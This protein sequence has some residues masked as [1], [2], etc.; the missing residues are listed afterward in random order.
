MKVLYAF[1]KRFSSLRQWRPLFELI[2]LSRSRSSGKLIVKFLIGSYNWLYQHKETYFGACVKYFNTAGP[3]NPKDHYFLRHRL[4]WEQLNGFLEKKYY[5]LLHAPRQSGKT[6]AILEYVRYLNDGDTYTALYL[7]TE[8]AHTAGNDVER[9]FYWL[10]SQFQTEISDQLRNQ[11]EAL[12]FIEEEIKC[13]PVDEN[14]LYRFLHFWAKTNSKPLIIF[15]DEI[16]G[17]VE[18]SLVSLLKQFRTG[19]TKRPDLFPQS[20]CLIGVRNLQDYKLQSIE[21]VQKSILL[22]PFNIIAD[23][24]LLRNFTEDQVREL[25]NQHTQETGQVF[26]DEAISYAFYVTQG[27]PWLVN[28]LAYQAC[29]RDVIDRS[30]PITKEVMEGAKEQLILRKD[31][32][33][34]SLLERLHEK[35]V[36]VII[37][38]IISGTDPL[39]LNSDDLAYVR[40]LGLI[41]K[42]SWEIANPLYQQVIP[43]T[44]T[45]MLQDLIPEQTAWYVD[46]A[47]KLDMKKLIAAF[48]RF[49]RENADAYS[50]KIDYKESFPHLL[51]MAFLQR[52]VNGGGRICREYALGSKRVDIYVEWQKQCFILELK[53]KRGEDTER[54]G[55]EQISGYVDLAKPYEAHLLIFNRDPDVPWEQKISDEV[56]TFNSMQIHI[57]KM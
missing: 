8:P 34:S 7:T 22:S 39:Y 55:L 17:L 25:Y 32:H 2:R 15:F 9:S 16:D 57:W 35:R 38:A 14:A 24:L 13:R 51:L 56:I 20:I 43:R 37:D 36:R 12:D 6:T 1:C 47:G 40:D 10:L 48:S 33:I 54:K 29:F 31:T 42:D 30:K 5:F 21:D 23:S 18:N 3:I 28:A 45:A 11:K 27:Q 50:T 4:N 49:Y 53:V 46:S 26:T 19:Y 52:V 41:K 44:L